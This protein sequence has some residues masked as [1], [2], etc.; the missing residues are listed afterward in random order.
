MGRFWRALKQPLTQEEVAH[1]REVFSS[2]RGKRFPLGRCYENSMLLAMR[3]AGLTYVVGLANTG[4]VLMSHAWVS[5]NGKVVDVTCLKTWNPDRSPFLSS[6]ARASLKARKASRAAVGQRISGRLGVFGT[7]PSDWFYIGEEF[8][9][10]EV[11]WG[12]EVLS[13][14]HGTALRSKW[15]HPDPRYKPNAVVAPPGSS[16]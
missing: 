9:D 2:Y 5:L 3:N 7:F 16:V 6:S 10:F 12:Y 1:L 13:G 8:M 15:F 14:Y 11:V 4:L